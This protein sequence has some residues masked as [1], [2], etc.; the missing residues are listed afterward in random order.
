MAKPVSSVTQRVARPELLRGQ[1]QAGFP[2][3]DSSYYRTFP[4]VFH[5]GFCGVVLFHGCGPASVCTEL[6]NSPGLRAP[7]VE[8]LLS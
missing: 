2:A 8:Q 6:S 5:S 3:Q 1:L 4:W 7:E